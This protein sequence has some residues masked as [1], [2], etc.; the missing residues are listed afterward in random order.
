MKYTNLR[1]DLYVSSLVAYNKLIYVRCIHYYNSFVRS[2][3]FLVR[4]D[5]NL[6]NERTSLHNKLKNIYIYIYVYM[7]I[8]DKG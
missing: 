4:V 5:T 3:L 8:I 6:S 1:Y 2:V 7:E